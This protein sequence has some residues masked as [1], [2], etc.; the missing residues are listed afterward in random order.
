MVNLNI[1]GN[2]TGKK[3]V[4][5]FAITY[6]VYILFLSHGARDE[7][8]KHDGVS[9]QWKHNDVN[10]LNDP[11]ATFH[12]ESF[13]EE[14]LEFSNGK[15]EES[16]NNKLTLPVPPTQHWKTMDHQGRPPPLL[17]DTEEAARA[18]Q[19]ALHTKFPERDGSIPLPLQHQE[20]QLQPY[21]HHEDILHSEQQ[22]LLSSPLDDPSQPPPLDHSAITMDENSGLPLPFPVYTEP[23]DNVPGPGTKATIASEILECRDNVMQFVTHASD[24]KDECEGLKRA[25]EANC[26]IMGAESPFAGALSMETVGPGNSNSNGGVNNGG[27][28]RRLSSIEYF[29]SKSKLR[30]G[31]QQLEQV[32]DKVIHFQDSSPSELEFEL[33]STSSHRRLQLEE[34]PFGTPDQKMNLRQNP[35]FHNAAQNFFQSLEEEELKTCCTSIQTVFHEH[36]DRKEEDELNDSRLF[37]IVAVIAICLMV[38]SFIKT[39]QIRWLPEAAGCILVGVFGGVILEFVPHMDFSFDEKFFLRV[40]LPPIGTLLSH[41]LESISSIILPCLISLFFSFLSYSL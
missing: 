26:A 38:K 12:T 27:N 14:E 31:I 34:G 5:G 40:M 37:V 32:W 28:G 33:E 24:T 7:L 3:F 2:V 15:I 11:S 25:Y 29:Q 9:P 30:Q 4:Y 36:C 41:S 39:F 23:D 18:A 19:A 17:H 20:Q 8:T 1:N 16:T 13:S 21:Q 6:S 35:L 10:D 22:Q